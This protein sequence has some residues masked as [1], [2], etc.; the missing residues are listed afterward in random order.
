[1]GVYRIS[2]LAERSGFAPST[3]RF[4]EQ[5]GLVAAYE[6][7]PAGYRLYDE[8][9]VERLRFI[10]RAKQ[11]GLP[12]EE[13]RDLLTAWDQGSCAPVQDRLRPLLDDK[14]GQVEERIAELT[15][16]CVQ[17]VRARA[18]LDLHTPAGPCNESCGCITPAVGGSAALAFMPVVQAAPASAC[19]SPTKA[20]S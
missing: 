11:L 15:A 10:S 3:L 20:R 2:E 18:D 12:L 1:M 8:A 13:I 17:L 7:T 6:R 5:A 16:F 9:A 19:C 4:Y 14:I